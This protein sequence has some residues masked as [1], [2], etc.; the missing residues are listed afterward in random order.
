[1]TTKKPR[2][3]GD[4]RRTRQYAAEHG[5]TYQQ[6]LHQLRGDGFTGRRRLKDLAIPIGVEVEI[7]GVEDYETGYRIGA[8]Q[9][10]MP[11]A[12]PT[13]SC[14]FITPHDFLC[15]GS[16]CQ[17]I[18]ENGSL[19]VE[20]VLAVTSTELDEFEETRWIADDGRWNFQQL[21]MGNE[22]VGYAQASAAADAVANFRPQLGGLGI[23]ILQISDPY[24]QPTEEEIQATLA[25]ASPGRGWEE[26]AQRQR[27]IHGPYWEGPPHSTP[28]CLSG[29]EQ[30]EYARFQSEVDRLL[31]RAA[32]DG[33]VVLM[34]G[35]FN[36][37]V[38]GLIARMG[39]NRFGARFFNAVHFE[40]Q[41]KPRIDEPELFTALFPFVDHLPEL[42]I[43]DDRYFWA[44][45]EPKQGRVAYVSCKG[46]GTQPTLLL[47]KDPPEVPHYWC[48][49]YQWM[50]ETPFW[51]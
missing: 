32:R 37:D 5:L 11:F 9:L 24:P 13:T 20:A 39:I 27:Q 28:H 23:V 46:L 31:G 50:S 14:A 47:L 41:Y 17:Q 30:K 18:A 1:M 7:H 3:S 8:E 26:W 21:L 51:D 29:Q 48:G 43:S 35:D 44:G 36:D 16:L 15:V 38:P 10:W 4:K 25:D 45:M 33:I 6:A 40:Y 2:N 22:G 19:P 34:S 49:S 12:T 42:P